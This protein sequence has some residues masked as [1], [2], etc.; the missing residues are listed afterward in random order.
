MVQNGPCPSTLSAKICPL[1]LYWPV[2]RSSGIVVNI[3]TVIVKGLTLEALTLKTVCYKNL[4]KQRTY[5]IE[6]MIILLRPR[7]CMSELWF[8]KSPIVI[9]A[10]DL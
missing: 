7:N 3:L 6:L 5:K 4:N 10:P 1:N 8:S 9:L 2:N